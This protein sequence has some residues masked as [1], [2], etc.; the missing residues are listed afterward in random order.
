MKT[1]LVQVSLALVVALVDRAFAQNAPLKVELCTLTERPEQFDGRLVDVRARFT[2]L[3]DREWAIDDVCFRPVLIVLRSD[4]RSLPELD[5]SKAPILSVL[6]KSLNEPVVVF[7][8]FIGRFE[9]S[10][11]A[12]PS[13]RAESFGRSRST[14]RLVLRDVTDVQR[15]VVPQR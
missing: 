13:R 10:G 4:L 12:R 11:S 7:A 6:T 15:I 2:N 8:N 14:M 9:W 5:P 1:R 3:K